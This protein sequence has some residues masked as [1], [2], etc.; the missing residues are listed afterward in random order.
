MGTLL[1]G[2]NPISN[3][4][5]LTA[6]VP[7]SVTLMTILGVHELGHYYFSRRNG[8]SATLPY[9]IP[10]PILPG[11][12]GA[13]I[14]IKSPILNR[15]ALLDIGAAGPIAGFIVAIVAMAIGLESS[16]VRKIPEMGITYKLGEPIIFSIISRIVIGEVPKGFD[17]YIGSIA[18]AGWIGAFVTAFNL[19]PIGQLDGGHIIY[20]LFGKKHEKIAKVAFFSLFPLAF[21][22]I[23][24]LFLAFLAL[25][26]K[27]NHPPPEDETTKLDLKRKVIG[28]ICILIFILCFTFV[29][30]SIENG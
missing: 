18:F 19:L 1:E 21:F 11:T 12:F 3:I 13:F 22:W 29:P 10:S 30:L 7:F 5:N 25:I 27:I 23:G 8:V 4:S 2:V 26:I 6:G 16:E 9:F 14:K 17:I 28:G 20:A 24:W 15:R